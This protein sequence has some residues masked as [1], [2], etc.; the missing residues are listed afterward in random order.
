MSAFYNCDKLENVILPASVENIERDAFSSCDN[1]NNITI[2]NKNCQ[3]YNDRFTIYNG[4]N[5]DGYYF[6]GTIHGYANSTAQGYAE[7]YGYNFEAINE[8][9]EILG[10]ANLDGILMSETPHL[11]LRSL[12]RDLFQSFQNAPTILATAI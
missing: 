5:G 8:S 10:D 1:L 12:Q 6:N 7:A 2:K 4:M 11:L 3:I 9:E